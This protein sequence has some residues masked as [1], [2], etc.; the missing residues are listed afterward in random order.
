MIASLEYAAV[1]LNVAAILVLGHAG[2]GAVKAAMAAQPAP[3]QISALYAPLRPAVARAGG[4]LAAAIRANASI[5]ADLL[6]TASPA[7]AGAIAE[8]K[9]GVAAAYYDIGS[10]TAA[11]LD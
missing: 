2:C 9:L 10:G 8:G 4:D 3:G 5:Q 1:V 6:R 11:L 7:I